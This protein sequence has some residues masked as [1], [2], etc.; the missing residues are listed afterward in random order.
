MIIST[1][2]SK[3]KEIEKTYKLA[4]KYGCKDITL[5]YC[6]SNYPSKKVNLVLI[7]LKF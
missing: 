3:I 5:L 4:K 2:L 1:G 6:V 7:I